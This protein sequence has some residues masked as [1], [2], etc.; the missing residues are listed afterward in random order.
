MRRLAVS[1]A[2]LAVVLVGR[3]SLRADP[4]ESGPQPGKRIQELFYPEA[5]HDAAHPELNGKRINPICHYGP[6]PTILIFARDVGP[7]LENLVARL[8]DE[9][10]R[11]KRYRLGVCVILLTDDS[12]AAARKLRALQDRTKSKLVSLA[13]FASAGPTGFAIATEAEWTVLLY[14]RYKVAVNQTVKK[15]GLGAK[16]ADQ[17][18][19]DIH[20]IT[21]RDESKGR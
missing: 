14:A 7:D 4:L 10:G 9:V 20:K 2:A 6:N 11:N 8:D 17:V 15:G 19:A 16:V 5:V 1:L 13:T 18:I 3:P 21:G 12:A